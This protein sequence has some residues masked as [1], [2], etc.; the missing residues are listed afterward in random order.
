MSWV[1]HDSYKTKKAATKAGKD[2]VELAL[3][4]GARIRKGGKKSRPYLLYI[5]PLKIKETNLDE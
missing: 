4:K 3:A 1:F 2:F 5:L